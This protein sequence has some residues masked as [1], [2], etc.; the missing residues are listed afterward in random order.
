MY[1]KG[2]EK[3]AEKNTYFCSHIHNSMIHTGQQTEAIQVSMDSQFHKQ[4]VVYTQWNMIR[5][6]KDS[7]SDIATMWNFRVIILSNIIQTKPG[8]TF[9]YSTST[10]YPNKSNQKPEK[11]ESDSQGLKTV[12]VSRNPPS[13]PLGN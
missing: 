4:T 9:C 1:P 6:F 13:F 7:N 2:L 8:Q 12:H 11:A 3:G 5:P 10:R